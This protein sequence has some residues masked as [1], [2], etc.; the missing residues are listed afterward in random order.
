MTKERQIIQSVVE[1]I[2]Q[3]IVGKK[4]AISLI[5]VALLCMGHVLLEDVPGVG[6]TSLVL[7]LVRSLKASGGRIQ[8]T[9]DTTP[10]DITGFSIYNQKTR[11]FEFRPGACMCNILLADEINRTS[12]RTQA[13]LLEIML[14][15][16]AT[17][18][19]PSIKIDFL[20]KRC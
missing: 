9:P 12:P 19:S 18:A 17:C 11:D 6:K 8:F 7:A 3:V 15:D 20:S 4:Q 14:D 5:M 16:A 2:E 1:N 13:T 10:S